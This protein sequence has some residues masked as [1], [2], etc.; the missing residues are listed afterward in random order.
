MIDVHIHVVQSQLDEVELPPSILNRPYE[1]VAATLRQEMRS[2]GIQYVLSMGSLS[3]SRTDPLG[4]GGV[5][6]VAKFVPGLYAI[7][8][9]NPAETDPEFLHLVEAQIQG[10]KVIA[11]KAF[12]G[13]L[14]VTPSSPNY[15]PY[16]ELAA[17]Y[18]L[19]FIFHTGDTYSRRA[20]L[21]FA[22]PLL[23]D[24]VAVDFPDVN[25]VIAH[26]GNPWLIDAA[27]VIYKNP[28]V[29]ADLSG[30]LVGDDEY[31]EAGVRSGIF[32][33]T[34]AGL[35]RMFDYTDRPDRFLYGSDWPLAPM[36]AYADWIR[37]IIPD[38][39]HKAVFED[40]AQSL[41]NIK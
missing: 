36:R 16:Y 32:Q 29:W 24:D 35:Q 30:I 12:L 37:S 31:F 22:Q 6:A 2:A 20:K 25:F 41:F 17:R 8:I 7:G 18:R 4:I 19:P 23:I 15:A 10:G 21:R 28:N 26:C 27:A 14:H 39:Y 11:L 1:E 9:A 38:A 33:E 40:N 5:L 3:S 13:Y 34:T